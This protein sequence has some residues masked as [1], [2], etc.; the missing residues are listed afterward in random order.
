ME[1]MIPGVGCLCKAALTLWHL[2]SPEQAL[3]RSHEALTLAQE[4]AHPH[5]L[6][7]ALHWAVWVY[8]FRREE[9]RAHERAEAMMALAAEQGFTLRLAGGR[10][11]RG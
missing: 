5:S 10:S 9:Q 4:L 3:Q 8:Q 11:W 6:V 2:G 7:I 1:G